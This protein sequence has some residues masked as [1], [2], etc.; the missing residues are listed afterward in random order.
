MLP[1]ADFD[2]CVLDAPIAA[3]NQVDMAYR[4]PIS[5]RRLRHRRHARKSF[6]S[7]A[8]SRVFISI[9][10]NVAGFGDLALHLATGAR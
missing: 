10:Q 5:R 2:A 6:A 1:L 8:K 3:L 9:P 4:S 7:S